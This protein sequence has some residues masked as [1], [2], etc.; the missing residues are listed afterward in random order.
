MSF[1]RPTDYRPE[2][3]DKIIE[4]GA[5]GCSIVEF[6]AELGC[7][8]KQ[9]LFNWAA[10]HPD[11]MEAFTRAKIL[12]EA[13]FS[14]RTR[15]NLLNRDFNAKGA[16]FYGRAYLQIADTAKSSIKGIESAKTLEEKS[17]LVIDAAL[18]GEIAADIAE[19]LVRT[20]CARAGLK[21]D[22]IEKR[23]QILHEK[24]EIQK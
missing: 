17:D 7:T 24:L 9:T 6:A 8:S 14:K 23:L 4:L 5:Q 13:A 11:F 2:F 1:G 21:I 16:E 3:C 12:A 18:S 22:E 19:S 15:E 10:A 20:I